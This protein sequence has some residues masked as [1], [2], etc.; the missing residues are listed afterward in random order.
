MKFISAILEAITSKDRTCPVFLTK[1]IASSAKTFVQKLQIHM[2]T[3]IIQGA[4]RRRIE[5][6]T[7]EV[8]EDKDK[9]YMVNYWIMLV[10]CLE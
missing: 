10:A 3:Q 1:I 4:V 5:Q 8:D 9:P 2:Q 7:S 6:L